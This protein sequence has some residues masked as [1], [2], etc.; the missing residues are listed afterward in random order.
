MIR[1]IGIDREGGI[2]TSTRIGHVERNNL[3]M[4]SPCTVEHLRVPAFFWD[5]LPERSDT[6]ENAVSTVGGREF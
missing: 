4:L 6:S 2:T 3:E 5:P 1:T